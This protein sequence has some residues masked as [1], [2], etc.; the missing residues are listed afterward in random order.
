MIAT[1]RN[2]LARAAAPALAATRAATVRPALLAATRSASLPHS[3][4]CPCCAPTRRAFSTTRIASASETDSL[5]ADL[6]TKL[7]SSPAF[8]KAVQDFQDTLAAKGVT[9]DQLAKPSMK[10]FQVLSDK[11]VRAKTEALALALREAGV[12][13]DQVRAAAQEFSTGSLF[14]SLFSGKAGSSSKPE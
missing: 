10:L 14:S 6:A 9:P 13:D 5:L 4:T 12:T 3:A 2:V 11:D 1:A 7:Q 8:L